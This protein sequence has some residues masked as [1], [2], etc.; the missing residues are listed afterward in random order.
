MRTT[1]A[2]VAKS[3]RDPRNPPGPRRQEK[4]L[5]EQSEARKEKA[6]LQKEKKLQPLGAVGTARTAGN[7]L[8]GLP[9]NI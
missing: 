2:S 4:A 8:M 5:Q 7:L 3:A 9:E 1:Y 6:R